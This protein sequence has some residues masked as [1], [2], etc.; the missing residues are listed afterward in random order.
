MSSDLDARA[1]IWKSFFTANG[2][3]GDEPRDVSSVGFEL[4]NFIRDFKKTC[5]CH[6]KRLHPAVYGNVPSN[7]YPLSSEVL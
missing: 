1:A 4:S 5:C 6:F 2:K 7:G 3:E